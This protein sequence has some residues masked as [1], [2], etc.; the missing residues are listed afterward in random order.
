V[1]VPKRRTAVRVPVRRHGHVDTG[2]TH[3]DTRSMGVEHR[4]GR[5]WCVL[6]FPGHRNLLSKAGRQVSRADGPGESQ[7]GGN[8]LNGIDTLP[9]LNQKQRAVTNDLLTKPGTRLINR[10]GDKH[11]WTVGLELAAVR[12]LLD[13]AIN[14]GASTSFFLFCPHHEAGWWLTNYVFH[15][16]IWRHHDI[17]YY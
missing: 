3:I 6:G 5:R 14:H 10:L 15:I 7:R 13:D 12:D 8:L 4:C 17:R 16:W 11:Q 1:K 9:Y 2:G